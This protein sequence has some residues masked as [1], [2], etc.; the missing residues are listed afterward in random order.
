LSNMFLL[1]RSIH[2]YEG[3]QILF[4]GVTCLVQ[5]HAR[6]HSS[7]LDIRRVTTRSPKLEHRGEQVVVL[8]SY[9]D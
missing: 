6:L 3:R 7:V 2:G 4:L 9:V 1:A 8:L 5:C